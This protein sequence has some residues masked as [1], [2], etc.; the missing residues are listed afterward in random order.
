MFTETCCL[1]M[2]AA[3]RRSSAATEPSAG[4][5]GGVHWLISL[6]KAVR[7]IPFPEGGVITAHSG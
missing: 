6:N 5:E 2:R 1:R 4:V 3:I 7:P